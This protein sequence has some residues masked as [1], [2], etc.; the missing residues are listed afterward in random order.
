MREMLSYHI[1]ARRTDDRA[2]RMSSIS[3][4]KRNQHLQ[5]VERLFFS[6]NPVIA[7]R[8]YRSSS[9][10]VAKLVSSESQCSIS[11]S[12]LFC[13]E[14]AGGSCGMCRL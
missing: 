8:S 11:R 10:P 6:Q 5:R 3:H 13:G 2:R 12:C 14:A 9:V 1:V 7:W 4:R